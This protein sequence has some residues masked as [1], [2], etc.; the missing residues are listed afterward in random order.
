[1][2]KP[3]GILIQLGLSGDVSIPQNLVVAKEIEMRGT[4]RF[5]EEFGMV[6]TSSTRRE[7]I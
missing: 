5:H 2:L 6:S 7:W 3:R 1:M 4:F